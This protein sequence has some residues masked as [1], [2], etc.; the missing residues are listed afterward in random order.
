MGRTKLDWAGFDH[1]IGFS[2]TRRAARAIWKRGNKEGENF[3]AMES[4]TSL[5]ISAPQWWPLREGRDGKCEVRNEKCEVL[6]RE[7]VS[8]SPIVRIFGMGK[9]KFIA[10]FSAKMVT[11]L[12]SLSVSLSLCLYYRKRE[13]ASYIVREVLSVRERE[14]E[15]QTERERETE[16]TS[17]FSR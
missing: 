16:V 12:P 7:S 14:R 1:F 2:I 15:I 4:V 10:N 6:A 8:S 17:P 13:S 11:S 5:R 9:C 3:L